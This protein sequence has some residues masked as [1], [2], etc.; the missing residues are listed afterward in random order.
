[1]PLIKPNQ[2]NYLGF[3][4]M[5][6]KDKEKVIGVA[7]DEDKVKAFLDYKPYGEE[8][9]A[10]FHILTKAYRG[11]PPN[12][13]ERFVAIYKEA[14]HELNPVNAAGTSFVDSIKVNTLQQEYVEIMN[15]AGA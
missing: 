9:N 8:E 11:L 7:L 10:D 2:L 4:G 1:M 6:K 12:E 13:F 3:I 14:G 15:Q 5:L